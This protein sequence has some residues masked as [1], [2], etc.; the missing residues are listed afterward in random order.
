[1]GK[2]MCRTKHPILPKPCLDNEE[3]FKDN[4][5]FQKKNLKGQK[6]EIC[7]CVCV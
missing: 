1:M 7:V 5:F 6:L 3:Y 2:I 4:F